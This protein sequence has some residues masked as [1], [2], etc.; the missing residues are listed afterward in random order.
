MA[1]FERRRREQQTRVIQAID[2]LRPECASGYRIACLAR[3]GVGRTYAILAHLEATGVVRSEW[4]AGPY[5][6]RRVYAVVRDGAV[7]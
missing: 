5:P 1:L 7:A 3:V 2:W 4:V 6:R